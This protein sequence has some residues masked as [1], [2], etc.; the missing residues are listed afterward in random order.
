MRGGTL[1]LSVGAV[2]EV[3]LLTVVFALDIE[4]A[5]GREDGFMALAGLT[6]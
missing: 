3:R 2:D 6:G 1:G 5:F 4:G